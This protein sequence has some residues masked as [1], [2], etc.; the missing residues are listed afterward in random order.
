MALLYAA[1]TL[2]TNELLG[3]HMIL[4][5]SHLKA[6]NEQARRLPSI[7][8]SLKNREKITGGAGL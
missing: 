6:Y 3:Q 4:S 7:D 5:M 8:S 2:K 1:I